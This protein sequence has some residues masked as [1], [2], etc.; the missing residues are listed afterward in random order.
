MIIY[1]IIVTYNAMRRSWIE[2]CLDSLRDSSVPVTP[3]VI[4]NGSTDETR[5][6]VPQRYPEAVWLP[7]EKNLGFGQANN[8]GLRYALEHDTDYVLLLNQDATVE[9]DTLALLLAEGDGHSLLSPLHLNGDGSDF[10]V[11]FRR[12][13]LNATSLPQSVRECKKIKGHYPIG[14]VCA[15]CWLMP[16]AL[17]REIGGF[18]PLFLQYGEDNNYYDRM[19]YHHIKSFLV[20]AAEMHHDRQ[21]HGSAKAYHH[22]LL[23]RILLTIA[24]D[25]S[26]TKMQCAKEM[27]WYLKQCYTKHF[28]KGAYIPGQFLY[29]LI[30]LTAHYRLIKK[31]RQTE[32]Q[33]GCHWIEKT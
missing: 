28:F 19:V 2:R 26:Q 25:I 20:P 29:E 21:I 15:A 14:E 3:I 30:W 31:S 33:K 18:N 4:D 6:F 27:R 11:N 13:T 1:A 7:Q 16:V 10:D 22:Q 8:I 32:R 17:V 12:F 5:T 24:C 9:P 23:H